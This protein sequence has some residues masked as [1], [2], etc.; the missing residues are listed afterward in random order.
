L[1]LNSTAILVEN[2]PKM[3]LTALSTGAIGCFAIGGAAAGLGTFYQYG[4]AVMG[5]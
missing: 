5:A 1:G 3:A 4:L 2:Y